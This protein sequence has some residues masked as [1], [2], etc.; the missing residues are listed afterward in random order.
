MNVSNG[1]GAIRVLVVA[2]YAVRRAGLESLVHG[3]HA[4][5]LAGSLQSMARL[6]QHVRELQPDVILADID[7]RDPAVTLRSSSS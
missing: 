2:A 6:A 1:G 3:D 4:L 5:H 7:D